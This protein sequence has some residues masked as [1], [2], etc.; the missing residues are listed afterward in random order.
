MRRALI[1]ALP[2]LVLAACGSDESA[3]DGQLTL[4][5][6]GSSCEYDGPDTISPGPAEFSFS[7]GTEEIANFVVVRITAEDLMLDDVQ[8]LSETDPEWNG[9]PDSLG[10][11]VAEIVSPGLTTMPDRTK[12]ATIDLVAGQYYFV[13]AYNSMENFTYGGGVTVEP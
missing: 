7:N 9:S 12:E 4:T 10:D 1:A 6:D 5:F 11:D 13:C 2:L 8:R 3:D